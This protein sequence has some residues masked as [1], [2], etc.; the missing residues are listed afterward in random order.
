MV[1]NGNTLKPTRLFKPIEV[2]KR[3]GEKINQKSSPSFV[4]VPN[5][6]PKELTLEAKLFSNEEKKK[7]HFFQIGRCLLLSLSADI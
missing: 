1:S 2:T 6:P 7:H 4:S 5:N 3:E